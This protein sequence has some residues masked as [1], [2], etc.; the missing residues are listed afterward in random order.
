MAACDSPQAP[1]SSGAN[2]AVSTL[3]TLIPVPVS[4][5]AGEGAFTLTAETKI[6][7][8]TTPGVEELGAYLA[9]AL[10]PATQYEFPVIPTMASPDA[11]HITLTMVGAEPALGDEGYKLAITE[12]GVTLVAYRPAGLFWGIQTLR[13]LFPPRIEHE[14]AQPGPWTLPTC[15]IWDQPRF[16]WRGLMLD[17]SRHF[18]TVEEVKRYI[19]LLAYYKLNRLH[20]HLTDDQGWRLMIQA[21]PRLA[22]YGGSTAVGGAAGGFY[23]QE[24]YTEIVTY[25][26]QRHI[27]IV[28]EIDMPGHTNAALASY[29][30]LNCDGQ[31]P[32]LYT[33]TDV[34]FSSLCIDKE[35]TYEFVDDVVR[36][37]AALTPG[38][39]LHIGGDE[40]HSTE[41]SDYIRFVERV[42][43]IVAAHNKVMI[44]WEEIS[45]TTLTPTTVAQHWHSDQAQAAVQQGNAVIL[46]PASRVYLDMKYDADT[47]LGLDWA[48][49]V[50][51]RA[52]Y[53]WD[54]ATQVVG[55][56]ESDMLG[57]EA[58]VWTETLDTTADLDYMI[59]P[60]LLGH[61]EIGW[62]PQEKRAWETY[63]QRLSAH[64]PRLDI[65]QVNAYRSAID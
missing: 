53:D 18:F 25:A 30:A 17:V 62:S 28:P 46:S 12:T 23:T 41:T 1:A 51:V 16:A 49:K 10:R 57:I 39:Y 42:Q 54:P 8:D 31:A 64:G 26:Q 40:A 5:T 55:V 20:L 61:A 33:G 22:E 21:W 15:T 32:D 48:G 63:K 38:P 35:L 6:Y 27:M 14:T 7:V 11:G 44:G 60:R 9:D 19:D 56:T 24:A 2:N 3:D 29:P 58:A 4:V 34:G 43:Q 65:W 45:Q 52:A 37:L 13:Q 47:P 36:E 59:F 50:N